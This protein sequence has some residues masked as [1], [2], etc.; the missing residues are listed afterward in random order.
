MFKP[1]LT[2]EDGGIIREIANFQGRHMGEELRLFM[3]ELRNV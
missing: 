1:P 3:P 2:C